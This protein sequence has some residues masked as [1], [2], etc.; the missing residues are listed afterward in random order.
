MLKAVVGG[1]GALILLFTLVNSV[2]VATT[3][4]LNES[5]SVDA[6]NTTMDEG[7][8]DIGRVGAQIGAWI[9][10]IIGIAALILVL[11]AGPGRL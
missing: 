11:V 10:Y 6:A 1:V 7:V 3:A 2:G 4:E 5:T 9:P 8:A